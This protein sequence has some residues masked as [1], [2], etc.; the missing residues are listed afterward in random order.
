MADIL[1]IERRGTGK[2]ELYQN[3]KKGI[4]PDEIKPPVRV[5]QMF[6][7]LKHKQNGVET[8]EYS[9]MYN[10]SRY[11]FMLEAPFEVSNMC[12]KVMKKAPVKKFAR[13]TGRK[14]ITAQMACE[15]KLREAQWLRTGCNAFES[16]EPISNPMSFWT[17]QDV[18]WYIRENNLPIA[19]VYGD[20]VTE[21]EA[22]GQMTLADFGIL[23]E[24]NKRC[25]KTTGCDRTGCM[26]CAYGL[27]LEKK[28][29]R[30]EKMSVTHPQLYDYVM[31][32]GDF[33]NDG[34]FKPKGGL[35]Y[36]FLIS[37]IN[38]HGNMSIQVPRLEEYRK[39]YSTPETER[40]LAETEEMNE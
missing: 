14:P 13:Q 11:L 39:K 4:I 20:I 12:C 38:L 3:L 18:L 15:S 32:G 31:R 25:L 10:K 35:G 28:T 22:E 27:H 1:G 24:E 23:S 6:G 8:G 7:T 16:K 9:R 40:Y 17:E 26:F 29:N 5:Q 34:M 2:R 21:D 30:F 33:A 36:W 37:W 19:E